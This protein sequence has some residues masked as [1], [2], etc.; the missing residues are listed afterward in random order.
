MGETIKSYQG[1][2]HERHKYQ[3]MIDKGGDFTV[4]GSGFNTAYEQRNNVTHI[5]IMVDGKRRQRILNHKELKSKKE[6]ALESME[7]ALFALYNKIPN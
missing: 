7:K 4:I 6:I 3:H 1:I 5:E 2:G